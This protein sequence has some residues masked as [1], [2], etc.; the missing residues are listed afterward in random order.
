MFDNE[1]NIYNDKVALIHLDKGKEY[2]VIIES[3]EIA[4]M[5]RMIFDMAW[6]G[7]ESKN[8]EKN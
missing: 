7:F 8:G 5:H 6:K 3:K 4:D 1:M 2:G